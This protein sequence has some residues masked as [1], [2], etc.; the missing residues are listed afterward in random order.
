MGE[1]MRRNPRLLCAHLV[2]VEWKNGAGHPRQAIGLLEDISRAGAA[3]RLPMPIGQGE[4]VRMYVAAASFGGIVRHCSAEFSAYSV[5]IE[6]TG[7]CWSPQVFQPDHLTDIA[8][9][10]GNKR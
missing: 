10:F 9:L 6:F 4:A 8:S 5:G 7:P 2:R 3:F 1:D